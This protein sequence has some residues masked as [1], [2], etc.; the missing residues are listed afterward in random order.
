MTYQMQTL[1][2]EMKRSVGKKNDLKVPT[3]WETEAGRSSPA[4]TT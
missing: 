2:R 1:S 4:W 3:T